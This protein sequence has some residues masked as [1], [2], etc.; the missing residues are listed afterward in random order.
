NWE[1]VQD[2]L[3]PMEHR[4][5]GAG[6]PVRFEG[7]SAMP[8]FP[9]QPLEVPANTHMTLLLDNSVLQTAYPDLVMSG[10][11]DVEVRFAYA[12]ALYDAKGE[13]GNRKEIA[14]RHIE[15]V[16]DTFISDGGEHRVY[17]SLWWRTWRYL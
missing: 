8:A 12:E 14:G 10:G 6:K 1:L 15:G 5:V 11:R 3:P 17:Q 13:K 7:L 9:E 4:L 2:L 16:A